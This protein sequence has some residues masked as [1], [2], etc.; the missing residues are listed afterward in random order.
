MDKKISELEKN[1][2]DYAQKK[3]FK[4][5][6]NKVLIDGLLKKMNENEE[7]Y[8]CRYCP[9]RPLTGNF[10]EDNKKIC[11]CFWHEKEITETGHCHCGLFVKQ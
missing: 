8:G 3:S 10:E 5:N 9:C 2:Q 1:Y 6:P 11:P 4:L 7:K